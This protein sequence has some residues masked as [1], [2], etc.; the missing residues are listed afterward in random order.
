MDTATD[1][2]LHPLNLDGF[3]KDISD[4]TF[5]VYLGVMVVL[6]LFTTYYSNKE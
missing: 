1:M 3:P 2:M 6:Y 5:W 4:E